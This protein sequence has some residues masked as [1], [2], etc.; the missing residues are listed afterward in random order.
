MNGIDHFVGAPQNR[1]KDKTKDRDREKDKARDKEARKASR[2]EAKERGAGKSTTASSSSSTSD[3]H[4][5]S[6]ERKERE[7]S[8][9]GGCVT[10]VFFLS[11]S[12][13]L[14][15]IPIKLFLEQVFWLVLT[16]LLLLC[17][18]GFRPMFL[19]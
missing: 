1:D 13:D 11:I 7:S 8:A 6:K 18:D 17:F 12:F 16:L 10:P 2:E 19:H 4:R 5:S 14:F 15:I 3:K 9:S